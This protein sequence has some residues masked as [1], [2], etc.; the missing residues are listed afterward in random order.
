MGGF[1]SG[2]RSKK[3]T[4]VESCLKLDAGGF[5]K[6]AEIKPGVYSVGELTW[7]RADE[8]FLSVP[9]W[10][11]PKT[12]DRALLHITSRLET[13]G[14]ET[15]LIE[16]IILTGTIPHFGGVRWWFICPLIVDG[17]TCNRRVKKL[18]LPPGAKYFGCRTCYSLIYESAQTHDARIG[19][20]MK[21]L[22]PLVKAVK[23]KD[24]RQALMGIRAYAKLQGWL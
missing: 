9:F 2:E 6:D 12:V 5:S 3:K 15:S 17:T 20:L 19:K 11:E 7:R 16:P 18:F 21:N 4:T 8:R 13:D 24:P 14:T 23:S 22:L 1:G 10:L